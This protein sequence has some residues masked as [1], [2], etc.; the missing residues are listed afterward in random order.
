M[1]T[2]QEQW[3]HIEALAVQE[4]R[5]WEEYYQHQRDDLPSENERGKT[6]RAA[7]EAWFVA[8]REYQEQGG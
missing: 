2:R 7:Y 8:Y 1:S 5:A 4:Q 3:R 6:W